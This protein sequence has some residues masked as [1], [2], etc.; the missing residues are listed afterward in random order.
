M[1]GGRGDD[2]VYG[3]EGDD[4][5]RGGDGNDTLAGGAGD[6]VLR[7]DAGD[8]KLFGESGNDRLY[9]GGGNDVLSGGAGNDILHGGAGDDLFIFNGGG[10]ND[11]V[12]DFEADHDLLR[13]GKNINDLPVHTADDVAAM[14]HNDHGHAMIDFGHGDSVTLNGVSVADLQAD[15]SR[16]ILVV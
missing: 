8:D 11:V 3:N 4:R 1:D 5:L 9:G 13:I 14:A 10:G 15:P 7:G 16:F 6:D 12:L 2:L